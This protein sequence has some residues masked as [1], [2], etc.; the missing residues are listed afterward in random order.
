[1]APICGS[2]THFKFSIGGSEDDD[3]DHN[4]VVVFACEVAFDEAG[5]GAIDHN[6]GHDDRTL[7]SESD[8]ALE[9]YYREYP[10]SPPGATSVPP[11]VVGSRAHSVAG[12]AQATV[13]LPKKQ[14]KVR[15]LHGG[16]AP[17]HLAGLALNSGM[18]AELDCPGVGGGCEIMGGIGGG[19]SARWR[20]D[21]WATSMPARALL[22][23]CFARSCLRRKGLL[24]LPS[25]PHEVRP[26]AFRITYPTARTH[27]NQR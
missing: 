15:G 5:A 17:Q 11:S 14:A 21:A 25:S 22:L 26:P 19:L 10:L 6:R 24:F 16:I 12:S 3:H 23:T 1:M 13:V 2:I 7:D 27:T 9:D 18:S 20:E 4:P 8:L